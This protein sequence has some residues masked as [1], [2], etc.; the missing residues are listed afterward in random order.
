VSPL[1]YPYPPQLTLI[2]LSEDNIRRSVDLINS[3]LH[4]TKRVDVFEMARVDPDRPI[5]AIIATLKELV[6]EG[7]FDHVAMSECNADTL[8]RA[9]AVHPITHVEIEVSPFCYGEETRRG[10]VFPHVVVMWCG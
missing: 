4:G 1:G 5:E 10:V 6:Q 3:T 9:N 8:R 7:K 2:S